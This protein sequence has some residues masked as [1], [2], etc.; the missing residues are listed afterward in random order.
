MAFKIYNKE[1]VTNLTDLN[2]NSISIESETGKTSVMT[3]DI[4]S[5]ILLTNI[6]LDSSITVYEDPTTDVSVANKL[7]VDNQ[8]SNV[9]TTLQT[10][11][12]QLTTDDIEEGSTNLY[13]TDTRVRDVLTADS[14]ANTTYVDIAESDAI[15]TANAYTDSAISA[16]GTSVANLTTDDVAEGTNRYYTDARAQ[17][18]ISTDATLAYNAGEVSMPDTGVTAG[19]YGSASEVPTFTVDAQGRLTV[20]STVTVA[21]VSNFDYDNA[22]GTMTIDTADGGSFPATITYNNATPMPEDVGG[23]EAGDTF[24]NANLTQ[25]LTNLLYPY[26]YPSISSF[27]ISGQSTTIEVGD[28][29]AGSTRTFVWNITNTVNISTN[30]ITVEDVT[31][32]NVY[33]TTYANDSTETIDI[34]APVSK[35]SA[36]SNT[37]R[38]TAQNTKGQSITRTYNVNWRWR[39]YHGTSA[40]AS[41]DEA[42]VES[43]VNSSLSSNFTGNKTFAAGGYKYV[44]Y[45]TLMGQK[46]NFTD[47]DTGFAVAMSAPVTISITN[48]FGVATDYYVH[49]STNVMAGAITIGVS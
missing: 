25:V 30:T 47:V 44:A 48:A 19:S 49:R 27:S 28:S 33:G 5:N 46:T 7:Y 24:T 17:A 10:S 36:N 38:I 35:I 29:V 31:N 21:G 43:L 8:V 23:Y 2:V 3:T 1:V 32:S 11:M 45:P 4:D 16:L 9:L 37:W 12:D 34:G 40:L 39:V 6:N 22:N 13:Y 41:L 42:G 20:A 14:I 15:T 18:A 26:Q